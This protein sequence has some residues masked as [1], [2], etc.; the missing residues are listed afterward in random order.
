M[1]TTFVVLMLAALVAVPALGAE[2]G[3]QQERPYPL[4]T[5]VVSGEDLGSM[6]DAVIIQ[7]EGREV[8]LCCRNCARKF[9]KDPAR[10]M[11]KLDAA[12]STEAGKSDQEDHASEHHH[13]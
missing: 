13:E 9:Q 10:Y 7:H 2:E 8:R 11:A 1:R 4:S 5:C 6:G 3:A 12:Q